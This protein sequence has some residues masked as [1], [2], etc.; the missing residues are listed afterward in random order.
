LFFVISL[1]YSGEDQPRSVIP[2]CVGA[3]SPEHQ[4]SK[5]AGGDTEMVSSQKMKYF[6]GTSGLNFKREHMEIVPLY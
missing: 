2:S 6:S 3:L 5:V 1:G 4:K